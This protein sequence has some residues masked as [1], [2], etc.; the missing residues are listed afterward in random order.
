[1]DLTV[2]R[3]FY[4]L[5]RIRIRAV[6][7][8]F[9]R[10]V[11]AIGLWTTEPSASWACALLKRAVTAVHRAPKHLVIDQGPQFTS[12][13]FRRVVR[14]RGMRHRFGAIGCSGSIAL[15]GRFG[16]RSREKAC[17]SE[18]GSCP[19]GCCSRGSRAG[20]GGTTLR[21]RTKGWTG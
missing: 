10:K 5:V 13:H 1:M 3:L 15:I 9:T 17:P 2:V 8:A 16:E 18:A 20:L 11:A 19:S 7:D 14:R 21:V 4:G 12:G 6:L